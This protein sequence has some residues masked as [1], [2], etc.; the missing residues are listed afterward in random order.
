MTKCSTEAFLKGINNGT[1]N[2]QKAKIYAYIKRNP[3]HTIEDIKFFSTGMRESSITARVSDLL[4][5]GVIKITGQF[6]SKV[7]KVSKLVIVTDPKEIE[8]LAKDRNKSKKNHA[9]KRLLKEDI[10]DE[11]RNVLLT[12]LSA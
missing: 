10:S 7:S 8:Q 2:S 9:I 6:E 3:E 12:E 5:M 1:F 11:T 4:D